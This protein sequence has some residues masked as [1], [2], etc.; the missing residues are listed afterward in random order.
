MYLLAVPYQEDNEI[1]K[2][3]RFKAACD[4]IAYNGKDVFC[5]IIYQH[6]LKEMNGVCDLSFF[7]KVFMK[8]ADGLFVYRLPGWESDKVVMEMIQFFTLTNQTV[9]YIDPLPEHLS[10]AFAE[11]WNKFIKRI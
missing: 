10:G 9:N 7:H 8:I 3:A 6:T 1:L 4:I 11:A 2:K 5:P